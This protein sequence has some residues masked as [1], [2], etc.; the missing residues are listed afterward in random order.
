MKKRNRLHRKAKHT[1]CPISM[2]RNAIVKEHYKQKITSQILD[3][4]IPPGEWWR[5]TKFSKLS[6]THKPVSPLKSHGQILLH[7]LEK[8]VQALNNFYSNIS[9]INEDKTV[10]EH[11]SGPSLNT[12]GNILQNKTY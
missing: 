11:R 8:A 3:K 2:V 12:M 4:D 7:P 1:N 5:I 6:N 9:S 10:P